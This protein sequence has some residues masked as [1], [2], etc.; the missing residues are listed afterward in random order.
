MELTIKQQ[1]MLSVLQSQ[2]HACW[3]TGDLRSQCISKHGV[4]PQ[5]R[6]IPSPASEEFKGSTLPSPFYPDMPLWHANTGIFGADGLNSLR[7]D[8]QS[9]SGLLGFSSTSI[10]TKSGTFSSSSSSSTTSPTGPV[11]S[12][13]VLENK[14][15][16]TEWIFENK[17]IMYLTFIMEIPILLR[18]YFH[19]QMYKLSLPT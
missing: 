12:L 17:L 10:R 8:S 13:R 3:C 15:G 18:Q 19:A 9:N 1:Y 7:M 11:K 5:S 4:D 16:L 14:E 2:Y 6:N